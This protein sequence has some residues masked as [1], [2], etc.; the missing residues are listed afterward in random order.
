MLIDP[1]SFL[2]GCFA[3]AGI[4]LVLCTFTGMAI[5]PDIVFKRTRGRG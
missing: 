3:G 4:M 1:A 2:L 5:F